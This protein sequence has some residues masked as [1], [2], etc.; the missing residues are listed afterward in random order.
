MKKVMIITLI[1]ISVI[2][3]N[4][5]G[6]T[7]GTQTTRLDELKLEYDQIGLQHNMKLDEMLSV[8]GDHPEKRTMQTCRRLADDHFTGTGSIAGDVVDRIYGTRQFAK[9][10]ASADVID[11]LADSIEIFAKYPDVF[12]S[13]TVVLDCG[14]D[15]QDKIR[16]LES[17]YLLV[18]EHVENEDDKHSILNGLS[19][20]IHSLE[21]WGENY[22][23]W[24]QTLT[25]T[26]GKRTLGIG[27]IIGI[28][29]GVGAVIG[30]LEGIRDTHKGQEGRVGII[31]GRALGEAAKTSVYA[32]IAIVL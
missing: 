25:G 28:T 19:T 18:D 6:Q 21:Y 30:T 23:E 11:M 29:D 12:D 1:A 10:T 2:L 16:R 3:L 32:F 17:I 27:A 20:T 5:C 8:Y 7:T 14:L 9:A 13:I 31:A 15:I 22:D 26:I 4:S 24:Q